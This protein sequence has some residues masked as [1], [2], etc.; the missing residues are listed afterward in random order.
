MVEKNKMF[1]YKLKTLVINKINYY[2]IKQIVSNVPAGEA[3][4]VGYSFTKENDKNMSF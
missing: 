2:L 1:W 4:L 3:K